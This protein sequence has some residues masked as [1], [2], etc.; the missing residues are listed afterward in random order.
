MPS[1]KDN[2]DKINKQIIDTAMSSGRKPEKIQLVAVSKRKSVEAMIECIKAGAKHFGENYIQE[3]ID[4][5]NQ[6]GKD[7]ACWHFIGHLQSNKAK[8]A[9][10]YFDYI[11][12]V[13]T[14]KLA[15]EID[16]Q[17]KKIN[18]IQK[19]LVQVNIGEEDTKSGAK[20]EDTMQLIT[21]IKAYPNLS[22]KGLMCMPPYYSDPDQ[23]RIYFQQLARIKKEIINQQNET[24]SMEHLSM[25]MSNDFKVAI[26]EGST[27][28]RVG[29]SI[30]GRRD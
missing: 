26:E 6:I 3:A 25:G 24:E 27:M 23:A 4:K 16:K 12:T 8:F 15:R 7:A 29:T 18:K 28:I 14:I 13:D 19:I 21:Q 30:F 10:K 2:L 11:H 9:V 20:I 1:I 17:A 5:I 22:I